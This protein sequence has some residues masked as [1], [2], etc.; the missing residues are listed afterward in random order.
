MV[1]DDGTSAAYP[2]FGGQDL[3]VG[4]GEVVAIH[5]LDL[6]KV[7]SSRLVP[8]LANG[9]LA[10]AL[11]VRPAA[12]VWPVYDLRV[13][14][15]GDVYFVASVQRRRLSGCRNPLLER[16]AGGTINQIRASSGSDVCS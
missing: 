16:T 7:T 8:L 9:G 4:D 11:H 12:V 10:R 5:D 13:D 15:R 3:A 2:A 1:R 14:P 6:V